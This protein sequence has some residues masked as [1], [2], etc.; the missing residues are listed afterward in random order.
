MR[1][2][3]KK[4]TSILQKM[5]YQSTKIAPEQTRSDIERLLKEFGIKDYQWT[6]YKGEAQLQFIWRIQ[7]SGVEKEILFKFK[8]PVMMA[9]KRTYNTKLNRYEKINVPLEAVSY[10]LLWHYLKSK[11]EAVTWGLESVE[12][13]FMSHIVMRLPTG[14]ETTLGEALITG[15]ALGASNSNPFALEEPKT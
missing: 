9:L 7:V 4:L 5:P 14:E 13:E 10:R 8:P 12:K 1:R 11:L 3:I 2:V 15:K 6:V